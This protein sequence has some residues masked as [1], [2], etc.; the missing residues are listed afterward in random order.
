[1]TDLV[2]KAQQLAVLTGAGISTASGIPDFR[3]PQ[4]V[5]TKNPAAQ[6]MFDIDEYVASAA[7]RAEAWKF[8]L[9]GAAWD[10]EPNAGHRALVEL[11]RQ[12]R[13]TGL[14]TQNVDG[15][16]QKAGS[17]PALVHELHGTVWFV[18]CLS[19]GRRIPMT[20]VTPRLAAGDEDPACEICGGILKSATVSFGQS[21][22]QQV[23]DAATAA[24]Q[25]ADLFLAIGTS[26]QVYPAAGLCDLALRAGVPL[27]I[28]N[29][30]PTPY[31]EEAAELI[32]APIE[33]VLPTLVT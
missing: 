9:A 30:E 20:E 2:R 10:A 16:H 26:L 21:L 4:G 28:L 29:A 12:G 6:A 19:C 7:V 3:G 17:S 13:L 33:Q 15:L 27:V 18:D 5:W 31:D 1:M 24:T 32:N 14:I 25:Q 8:R 11:E 22:D 23:L